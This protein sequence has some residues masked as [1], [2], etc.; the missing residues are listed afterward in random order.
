M[1]VLDDA[2]ILLLEVLV[3]V[4]FLVPAWDVPGSRYSRT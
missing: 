2:A 1:G 4:A 3:E